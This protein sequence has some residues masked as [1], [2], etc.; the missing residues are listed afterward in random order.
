M[1]EINISLSDD[2]YRL[3]QDEHRKMSIEWLR[4]RPGSVPPAFESWLASQVAG[5][6]RHAADLRAAVPE[7]N[8][9]E[10]RSFAAIE[11][12][13]TGLQAHGF[14]FAFL[15][16]RST[17]RAL[18][19]SDAAT[20]FAQTLARELGLSMQCT[21]RIADLLEYYSKSAK[22]VADLAHVGVTGRAYGALHEA[23]RELAERSAK[24]AA[25][26]GDD[27]ALG[28]V[29]GAAAILVAVN[30]M[31]RDNAREKTEAFRQQL[32]DRGK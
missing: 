16:K 20:E 10:I 15:G 6:A 22:E 5:N 28:R 12:L 2:E 25:R 26:L 21:K 1:P 14:S 17:T 8:M 23:W 9:A 19:E 32:R 11:K 31:S 13:I 27:K 3:L 30:A 18:S 29:E 4:A 7:R 24:A